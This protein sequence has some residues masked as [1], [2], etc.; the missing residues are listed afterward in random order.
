MPVMFDKRRSK[1]EAAVPFEPNRRDAS[2]IVHGRE[3]HA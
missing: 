2:A 3:R 1:M